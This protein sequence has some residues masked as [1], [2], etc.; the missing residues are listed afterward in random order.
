MKENEIWEEMKKKALAAAKEVT[1][2]PYLEAGAVAATLLS[3]KGNFYVGICIDSLCNLGV[4]AERNAIF[5]MITNHE[6]AFT[7]L[8]VLNEKG[9]YLSPCGACLELIHQLMPVNY[10]E[11]EI[12]TCDNPYEIHYLKE[13]LPYPWE[14]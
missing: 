6:Y 2:S 5:Q 8:L 13:F 3:E 1:I 10:G 14:K 7:K 4:C 12:L 11:I 9:E